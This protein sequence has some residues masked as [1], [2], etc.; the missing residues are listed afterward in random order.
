MGACQGGWARAGGGGRMPE[1]WAHAGSAHP[2]GHGED[3]EVGVGVGAGLGVQGVA[4]GVPPLPAAETGAALPAASGCA[5]SAPF[6]AASTGLPPLP[7]PRGP[8][9]L[10]P[11]PA[12][13]PPP[14][15]AAALPALLPAPCR[16]PVQ[17]ADGVPPLHRAPQAPRFWPCTPRTFLSRG[18]LRHANRG[19]LGVRSGRDRVHSQAWGQRGGDGVSGWGL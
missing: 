14:L 19:R 2:V 3:D 15:Q 4:A 1:G 16:P 5:G 18:C 13:A 12:A 8:P 11:L 17:A 6:P 10:P 7:A 9:A